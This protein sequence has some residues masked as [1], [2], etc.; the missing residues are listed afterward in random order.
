LN[1][2]IAEYWAR[3]PEENIDASKDTRE[4][5]L[6]GK[7]FQPVDISDALVQSRRK[8][9]LIDAPPLSAGYCVFIIF[10]AMRQIQ[11][12]EI[13]LQQRPGQVTDPLKHSFVVRSGDIKLYENETL[14][15]VSP[16]AITVG[17]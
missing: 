8:H 6:W 4:M 10:L 2:T 1:R 5:R 12:T 16:Q 9:R 13:L 15:D 3:T 7:R 17:V 14:N 11:A